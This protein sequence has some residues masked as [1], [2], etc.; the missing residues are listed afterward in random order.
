V[1]ARLV[2][3]LPASPGIV[4]VPVQVS[5]AVAT[6]RLRGEAREQ[7][8]AANVL[9]RDLFLRELLPLVVTHCYNSPLKHTLARTE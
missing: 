7:C 9:I 5:G 4:T 1:R 2:A 6:L 8:A 3:S